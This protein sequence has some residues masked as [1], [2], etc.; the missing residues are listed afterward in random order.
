M[1][2]N[3]YIWKSNNDTIFFVISVTLA[4]FI[5]YK[6]ILYLFIYISVAMSFRINKNYAVNRRGDF[7]QSWE[8]LAPFATGFFA[9]SYL[10]PF[11]FFQRSEYSHFHY[12]PSFEKGC[13]WQ[14]TSFRLS[15]FLAILSNLIKSRLHSSECDLLRSSNPP[16]ST[17]WWFGNVHLTT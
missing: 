13:F 16:W 17:N 10:C 6:L 7:L 8:V 2:F 5:F 12:F 15:Y 1:F 11:M 9:T 14:Q 3:R 4:L